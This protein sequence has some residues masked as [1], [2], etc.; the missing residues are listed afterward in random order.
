MIK[1]PNFTSYGDFKYCTWLV[2][3]RRR[4]DD[5]TFSHLDDRYLDCGTRDVSTQ[6]T[7][8]KVRQIME[9]RVVFSWKYKPGY[10]SHDTVIIGG[11]FILTHKGQLIS[12]A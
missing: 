9:F 8:I 6:E 4:S 11:K 10:K 3:T 5:E 12:K 2:G 1:F 7:Y